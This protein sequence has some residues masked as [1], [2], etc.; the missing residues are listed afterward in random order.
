[1][2]LSFLD[3]HAFTM[4]IFHIFG[5]MSPKLSAADLLYVEK[6]K[7]MLTLSHIR[8]GKDMKK[9]ISIKVLLLNPLWQKEKMIMT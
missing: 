9:T 6:I 5:K 4:E 1:M 3:H 8:F 7:I 2:F